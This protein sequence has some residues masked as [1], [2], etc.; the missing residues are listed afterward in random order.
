MSQNKRQLTNIVTILA[1]LAISIWAWWWTSS[2]VLP[3]GYQ[4][5]YLHVG[6]A[7]DLWD[8]LL[9]GDLWHLR[10][11][12]YTRYWPFG[13][14]I[15]PWPMATL[16]G[17]H[18]STLVLSNLIW[19]WFLVWSVLQLSK[20]ESSAAIPLLVLFT[21]AVYG[22]LV[23]FEPNLANI[24]WVAA[25]V[26]CLVNSQR[27]QNRTWV[28]LWA[29]CLGLGLMTDRLSVAF[30]LV[31]AA[32]PCIWVGR[33]SRCFRR[34]LLEAIGIVLVITLA[35]YREFFI[36][37]TAEVFGQAPVGEID[38]R[39]VLTEPDVGG[40]SLYYF[41]VLL[42]SQAGPF[43]GLILVLG[44][45]R[46]A[47]DWWRFGIPLKAVILL[48]A[49][50]PGILF[51][52]VLAKKQLYYTLPAIVPLILLAN[53]GRM[54]WLGVVGGLVGFLNL[55][56]GVGSVG[57][58]WL[59]EQWVAP[60]HVLIRP[61]SQYSWTPADLAAVLPDDASEVHVFSM[62]ETLYEG[63][64]ALLLREQRPKMRFR[65]VTLDP[66]GVREFWP[67][68]DAFV[69]FSTDAQPWPSENQ[70]KV[71]LIQDYGTEKASQFPPIAAKI[72]RESDKFQLVEQA[73]FEQGTLWCYER[74]APSSIRDDE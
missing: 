49:C 48:C 44:W 33:H 25:G 43:I 11:Y 73:N 10:Y 47:R 28:R 67:Q 51:F 56:L 18:I 34:N 37:N 23:R 32:L 27:F 24:A 68:A 55:G 69:F 21:P 57:G 4:N 54:A 2:N 31:P 29:V 19:L 62:D 35:Y 61:P 6:N 3:D 12:M 74:I 8:S 71:E 52:T 13:F 38:S 20:D 65:G 64:L 66:M 40:R 60:R 50:L 14:Y 9:D 42:D 17:M 59:P 45:L 72:S 70:I 15:V 41:W 46:S 53:L 58:T 1:A 63:Y 36:Q 16:F 30:F 5:E 39:G 26:L 22:T 7:F